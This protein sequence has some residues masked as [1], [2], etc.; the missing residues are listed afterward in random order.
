MKPAHT[1][2]TAHTARPFWAWGEVRQ[3]N[4][5]SRQGARSA[6]VSQITAWS[7]ASRKPGFV[8]ISRPILRVSCPQSLPRW[9]FWDVPLFLGFISWLL[10]SSEHSPT[11]L[12][13]QGFKLMGASRAVSEPRR[14]KE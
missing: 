9:G 10:L 2:H 1:A 11:T 7:V 14:F 3:H 5:G 6:D 13:R 4:P 8:P 12:R